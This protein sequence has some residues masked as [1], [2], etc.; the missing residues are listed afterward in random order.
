MKIWFDKH[1]LLHAGP[2]PKTDENSFLFTALYLLFKFQGHHGRY[3][4]FNMALLL[5]YTPWGQL[6]NYPNEEGPNEYMSH[7]SLT[8]VVAYSKTHGLLHHGLIWDHL[9]SHWLNL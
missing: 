1:N 4:D 9:L 6:N 5:S 7:D 2:Q 8:G 3:E